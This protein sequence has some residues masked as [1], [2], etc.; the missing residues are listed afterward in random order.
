MLAEQSRDP[1]TARENESISGS[2]E[3]LLASAGYEVHLFATGTS[4][5][6][7]CAFA[8]IDCLIADVAIPTWATSSCNASL[9]WPGPNV[10]ETYDGRSA[11]ERLSHG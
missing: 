5:L 10:I 4:L 1:E 6:Q 9:T 11:S 8:R 2:V 3:N 7:H